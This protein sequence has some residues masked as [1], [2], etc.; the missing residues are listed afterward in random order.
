MRA[1]TLLFHDV[2]PAGRW[3]LSGFSGADADVYK[4]DC[5]AF[6]AHLKAISQVLRVAPITAQ[7]LLAGPQ[8]GCP[9]LLT[10]DDGGVSALLYAADILDEFKWKAHFFVT[11]GRI[12]TPGFL[13]RSQIQ[14]LRR[15]GHM[16]GS[17]SFSHPPRMAC[18]SP[19]Q[20]DDEWQ[21]SARMLSEILG[22]PIQVASVPGGYY[23]REVSRSAARTGIKLLFNSEPQTSS[24]VV[25]RCVVLGRFSAQRSTPPDWS[26]AIVAG[27]FQPRARA[28]FFWNAKKVAKA[29]GGTLWL[30]AR[31]KLLERRAQTP[32]PGGEN[33]K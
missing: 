31:V 18:C 4:I 6:R 12:G 10:F 20:L 14:Q 32:P 7:D 21:R 29:L 27:H 25:D 22:E 13:D 19:A 26:A 5:D 30:R 11:A 23:S 33:S 15:R 17:H 28:Y 2:V 3:D 9:F 24:S 1:V 8:S 16:I